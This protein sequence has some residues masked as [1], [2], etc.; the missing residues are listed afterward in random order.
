MYKLYGMRRGD[1][2]GAYDAWLQG[3]H[4]DDRALAHEAITAA[5][6]GEREYDVEFRVVWPSGAIHYIKAYAQI[7]RDA[8]GKP[9]R[10]TGVNFDITQRKQAEEELRR[11]KDQL[12]EIVERRTAELVLA[13]DSAEAANKA[14]SVFLASMSHELRTPMNAILGFSALMRREPQLTESQRE[15]LDII[16]RSGEH[17]LSLINDVLEIAKIEAGRTQLA[18]APFDLG[19]MVRDVA[20]MMRLRAQEKGLQL[21]LD[22]SSEFPRYIKGDEARLRQVLVNLAGNAVKFTKYGGVT[23][24]LGVK[25]NARDHLR[26][27]SRI[28]APASRR[29]TSSACSSPSCNWEKRA[30]K[31]APVWA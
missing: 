28:P 6:L 27:R 14:K 25:H 1:F 5:K 30:H 17:L 22:Q 13:R 2:A 10:M 20:D 7:V 16:N 19:A 18:I 15:N 11:Y 3:V 8:Q 24:R 29:K 4:P 21:L 9:Q 23:I 26:W 12:E 31:K